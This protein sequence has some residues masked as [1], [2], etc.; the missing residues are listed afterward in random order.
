MK[1][2]FRLEALLRVRQRLEEV[3]EM[4]FAKALGNLKSLEEELKMQKEKLK[5]EE[6]RLRDGMEE[7]IMS[8]DFNFRCQLIS[9]M[10]QKCRELDQ[11]L[12]QAKVELAQARG[13]LRQRHMDTELV[14]GLKDRDLKRYLKEVDAELQKELDELVSLSHARDRSKNR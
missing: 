11:R 4:E 2:K 9:H 12:K 8:S 7:G 14:S 1:F 6:E 10:E 5:K 13:Q 3:A